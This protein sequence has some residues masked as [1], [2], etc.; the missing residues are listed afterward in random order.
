[1]LLLLA[2]VDQEQVTEQKL[3][4]LLRQQQE[5]QIVVGAV[6]AMLI[7]ER[8]QE[9]AAQESSSLNTSPSPITKSSRAPAHGL[10]LPGLL[11]SST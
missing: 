5:P 10:A 9:Q 4:H 6:V 11:R 1:M 3:L 7:L 8:V 2:W